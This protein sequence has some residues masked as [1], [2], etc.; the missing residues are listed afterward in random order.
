VSVAL[1][2][3]VSGVIAVLDDHTETSSLVVLYLLA[4]LPLAIYWGAAFGA[5]VSVLS[6]AAFDFWFIA[7]AGEFTISDSEAWVDLGVFLVASVVVSQLAGRAREQARA[8]ARLAEEQAALRRVATLVAQAVP[9]ADIFQTV[10]REIALLSGADFARM[11]RYEDDGTVTGVAAWSRREDSQLAVGTRIVLS[12][13]SIA[14]SVRETG[15]AVRVD[16]FAGASGPIADE[17]RASGIR[18]SVGCPIWVGGQLWGVIA[19]SSKREAAFPAE[20]ESQMGE[21]TELVATAVANAVSSGQLAA[22]RARVVAAA[23]EARRKIE[24]DLH[25]GIQQRLVTLG[26]E[27]NGVMHAV[28]SDRPELLAQISAVADDVGEMIDELR[29]ISRG[30]H[31]A[32]L[33]RGGLEPALKSLAR[34]SGV[35]VQL[36]VAAVD[37][38]PQSVEAAVYYTVSEALTNA[39]KHADASVVIVALAVSDGR[40]RLSVSDDGVGG[41][42][43]D[44]GSGIVGLIDRVEALQGTIAMSS[45]RGGGTS[46]AL[47]LPVEP[48]EHGPDPRT[49]VGSR[50]DPGS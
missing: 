40:L 3:A 32:V 47:E 4:V 30:I 31:P 25:D 21:F 10:T 13:V 41:A 2:A 16:S 14:A 27:L 9:P 38:L 6:T 35:P 50:A 20:M 46:I 7:P 37:R 24:R 45:P 39:T 34:R 19:A 29:E 33:S 11:E 43:P 18:S 48:A 28:P 36:N 1:V 49:E 8:S 5:L 22:S 15:G 26:L 23:D 42:D 44:H 12:G 17:A